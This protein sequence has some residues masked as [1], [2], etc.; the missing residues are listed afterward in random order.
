MKKFSVTK[1]TAATTNSATKPTS[2]STP[3]PADAL[4]SASVVGL[5]VGMNIEESSLLFFAMFGPREVAFLRL[6]SLRVDG[7]VIERPLD[8]EAGAREQ[9]RDHGRG[10][11]SAPEDGA[12]LGNRLREEVREPDEPTFESR[13]LSLRCGVELLQH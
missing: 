6:D 3:A 13:L 10:G 1:N 7:V 4:L 8:G 9:H 5:T 12:R 2:P 11:Q